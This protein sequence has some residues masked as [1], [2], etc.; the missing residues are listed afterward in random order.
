MQ[1]F[2]AIIDYGSASAGSLH[3]A[4][5]RAADVDSWMR[6]EM[7]SKETIE[8][9]DLGPLLQSSSSRK[10]IE[11]AGLPK[12]LAIFNARTADG[13]YRHASIEL[14]VCRLTPTAEASSCCVISLMARSTLMLFFIPFPVDIEHKLE[15]EE[16][17]GELE[18]EYEV[19]QIPEEYVVC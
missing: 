5:A 15:Q 11:S 9:G 2:A 18:A 12:Y 4:P 1:R 17:Y 6:E 7:W 8:A 10:N 13:T 19:S 3:Q 16:I 14:I